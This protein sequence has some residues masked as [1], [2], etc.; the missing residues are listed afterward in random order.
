MR[1]PCPAFNSL[2]NKVRGVLCW[3]SSLNKYKNLDAK[4]ESKMVEIKRGASGQRKFSSF[5]AIILKFPQYKD[6]LRKIRNEDSNGDIDFDEF[7]KCLHKL[8]VHLTDKEMK[9]LSDSCDINNSHGIQFNEF[10]VLLCLVYLLMEPSSFTGT[11]SAL[12]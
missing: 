11:V 3:F 6:G 5:N 8:Q 4:L 10:I 12:K 7:N 1:H 2:S 9:D